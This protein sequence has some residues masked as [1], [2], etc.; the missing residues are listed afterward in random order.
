MA[1]PIPGRRFHVPDWL[2]R[3]LRPAPA[4]WATWPAARALLAAGAIALFGATTHRLSAAGLMYFGAA[5]AVAFVSSGVYRTRF[6]A[7]AAQG[8]GAA[9]G[10]G[11]GAI[12]ATSDLGKV[13]VATAAGLLCG[14]IG[15]VGR[16][17]TAFAL[18]MVIG[19]SYEQFGGVPLPWPE[20][21]GWYL[22]GTSVV[23]LAAIAPLLLG[24]RGLERAAIADVYRASADLLDAIGG[25][26]AHIKRR[27][28]AEASAA[29][30]AAMYDHRLRRLASHREW[31]QLRGAERAAFD[32]ASLYSQGRP[33][34]PAAS[35]A[36]RAAEAAVRSGESLPTVAFEGDDQGRPQLRARARSAFRA[37]TAPESLAAG[38]RLAWCMGLATALTIVLHQSSHSYWL[39]LTVA[40]VVRPEYASVFVRTVNRV[41]GSIGG[42]V[43]AAMALLILPGGWPVAIAASLSIGWAVL[44]APK[45]YALS[46]IGIT[47]SALL[48][49]SLGTEDPV[50]PALRM[51]DTLAGCA[52]AIVFGYLLWPGRRELPRSSRPEQPIADAIA[53]LRQAA[54]VP[55]DRRGWPA[56]RDRAYLSA[57]HYRA[58]L[59]AALAE[60]PPVSTL[61]EQALPAAVALEDI[62]DG[63]TAL[64]DIVRREG[65]PPAEA[66]VEELARL[67]AE[68]GAVPR[69]SLDAPLTKLHELC[70]SP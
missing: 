63:I 66:G 39:P 15:A 65:R 56:V 32:A 33:V 37:A 2:R 51:L 13:V 7:L 20:K 43:F 54:R 62:A 46:V 19:I 69:A 29:S 47:G 26:D 12:G 18:M 64:D 24:R 34:S 3:S 44:S 27:A 11:V 58:A 1:E 35:D 45:L 21:A 16:Q 57:H 60:P 5:C 38:A 68:I 61:A 4:R 14:M 22:V 6:V 52:V 41:A 31:T 28:L 55:A 9:V 59:Q 36:F 50:Y 25:D 17:V 49:A 40:V 48:S 8:L 23:S 70:A 30:R 53:Y 42:A 67:I 10:L